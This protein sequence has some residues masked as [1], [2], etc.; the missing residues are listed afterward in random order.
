VSLPAPA[1]GRQG[2]VS[3]RLLG[4]PVS[5]H[6]SFLIVVGLFGL[7]AGG[8]VSF[9]LVWL[10]VATVSV[11]VHEL[12]HAL[13]A[14]PAGGEPEISL[15]GMAG[16]TRWKPGLASRAR[17]VAVSLAGPGVGLAFGLVIGLVGHAVHPARG[18]LP[19]NA[20]GAAVFVNVVWG[21][22]NLL[23]ILPL[24]GGQVA[25]ALMPGRDDRARL[26]RV[27]YLSIGAAAVVAALAILVLRQPVA[28]AFVIYIAAG[29]VQTLRALR[30]AGTGGPFAARL[31]A[32]ER[33]I[34]AGDAEQALRALPEPAGTPP[35][36]AAA[37][38]LLRAMALL[39]LDRAREAQDTLLTGL[40]E[41][42]RIDPTFEATVLLA[43]GQDRLA[44][45][46]LATS[47]RLD[48]PEW[49]VRELTA[50]LARRG[51]D[52]DAWLG[53]VSPEAAV[54]ALSALYQAG[55]YADA[56]RWGDRA[57]AG[58]AGGP[59]VAY[60]TARAH[61]RSGDAGR[62]L[63]A[64][65]HAALLGWA[66]LARVEDDPRFAPVRDLPG[67]EAVARR[68]HDNGLGAPRPH[69]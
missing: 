24:D 67:Y 20:F 7:S 36:W 39:R 3:F 21:L 29:N 12:G 15:Y 65:D 23:P 62:A 48:P 66:D 13:V 53:D 56:A 58:V 69:A 51:E 26:A 37:V 38:A 19:D 34:A 55:R 68:I 1:A 25:L 52:V 11:I 63:R 44:R 60:D 43:N 33:A 35:Q 22:F 49:A 64:L 2:L 59:E 27:A 54:G 14:A 40:P 42:T 16:L 9:A 57:L 28:G 17:R 4:F 50:L 46:R 32:A 47:L 8:G 18:T 45:E 10:A 41:G 61:T 6:A 30:H 31:N 5:I